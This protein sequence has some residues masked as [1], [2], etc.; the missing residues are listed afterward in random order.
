MRWTLFLQPYNITIRHIRGVEN[1]IADALSRA[2]EGLGES[3][4]SV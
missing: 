1:V 2:P 4:L 3:M